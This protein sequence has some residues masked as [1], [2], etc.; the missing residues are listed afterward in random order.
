MTKQKKPRK[1]RGITYEP[2]PCC[3]RMVQSVWKGSS[4]EGTMWTGKRPGGIAVCLSCGKVLMFDAALRFFVA[5]APD[6]DRVLQADPT[7]QRAVDQ[8]LRWAPYFRPN[9]G[10][11]EPAVGL[12]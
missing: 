5:D 4:T 11:P 9:P 1:P 8:M 12:D 7:L 10:P 3:G 6:L 2:H